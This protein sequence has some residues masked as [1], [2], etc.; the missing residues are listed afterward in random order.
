MFVYFFFANMVIKHH[1]TDQDLA[2]VKAGFHYKPAMNATKDWLAHHQQG[3]PV[4][5]APESGLL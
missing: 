5:W 3:G 2:R 1:K 4:C